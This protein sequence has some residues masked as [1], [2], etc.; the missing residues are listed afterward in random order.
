MPLTLPT[1]VAFAE[2]S[3]RLNGP[4]LT[5]GLNS[6]TSLMLITTLVVPVSAEPGPLSLI[7]TVRVTLLTDSRS[8]FVLSNTVIS[9]VVLLMAKI[10]RP[11]PPVML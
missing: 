5:V 2:F 9:P 10:P 8:R 6:F 7:C 1:L 3:S 11:L 4:P